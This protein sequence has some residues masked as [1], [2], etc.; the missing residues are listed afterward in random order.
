MQFSKIFYNYWRKHT[1][2]CH[3]RLTV[4]VRQCRRIDSTNLGLCNSMM[5]LIL[6]FTIPVRHHSPNWFKPKE[7]K[8]YLQSAKSVIQSRISSNCYTTLIC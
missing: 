3:S 8:D 5:V 4:I 7:L 1:H 6:I 2:V